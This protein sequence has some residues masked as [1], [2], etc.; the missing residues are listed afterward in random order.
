MGIGSIINRDIVQGLTMLDIG[1][2]LCGIT[3]NPAPGDRRLAS[4]VGL[5]RKCSR[6]RKA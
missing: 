3:A 1:L 5:R 4:I 6:R 2:I